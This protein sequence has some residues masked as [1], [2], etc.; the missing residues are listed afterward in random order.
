MKSVILFLLILF[1]YPVLSGEHEEPGQWLKLRWANDVFF[2]TDR[3]FSNGFYLEY[4]SE[5]TPL[6][7]IDFL[8]LPDQILSRT[9]Y[10]WAIEQNIYTP[11]DFNFNINQITDRPFAS[12]LVLASRK[13]QTD[14]F[15]QLI[16]TSE[17]EL[18]I[19]GKYSGGEFI[20][21]GIHSI[22][23]ASS[24]VPGWDNQLQ[25]EPVINYGVEF[26]KGLLDFQHILV[27]G[28]AGGKL[29]TPHTYAT[30]GLRLRAGMIED[31]LRHL[32]FAPTTDWQGYFFAGAGAKLVLYNAT[33]QGGIF[34]KNEEFNPP[35]LNPYVYQIEGGFN[36][37]YKK[38]NFEIGVN[39]S[40]AEFQSGLNHLWGYLSFMI[41]M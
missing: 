25:S 16:T 41:M 33:I 21:N 1:I 37:S 34:N 10:G 5:D 4:Y 29:G 14:D 9:F 3:Y 15:N 28:Y 12:Y 11:N 18:G 17:I 31:Y 2:Q 20:Q 8:H 26:E 6:S 13:V 24:F 32:D 27:S 7:L 40:S 38:L 35:S 23:P 22:L 30:S 39:Y 36:L 19:L